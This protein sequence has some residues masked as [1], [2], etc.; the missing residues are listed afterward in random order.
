MRIVVDAMGTDTC[1][2]PDVEGAVLAAREL[3]DTIILV[4]DEIRVRAELDKYNTQGLDLRVVHAEDSITMTDTP[5][6]VG[7][8]KPRSS[9]HIGMALVRDGEADAF[10]TMGNTGVALVIA[11][12]FVLR[13]IRGVKRPA[14]SGIFPLRGK[15]IVFLDVGANADSKPE[16]LAQFAL[17]GSIYANNALGLQ[18]PRIGLLSNGEEEGKGTELVREATT[19]IRSLPLNFIG[20]IEPKEIFAAAADVVVGDGF[21]GNL[22]VKTYEASTRYLA[23][24]IRDEVKADPLSVLGGLMLRP[25][26]AR[27]RRRIDTFEVGGAPLLG[28][29]GVVIIGHG[30]SNGIAVKNAI[31]Q[32]HRAVEG[33]IVA[34]IDAA[35]NP[36]QSTA[37]WMTTDLHE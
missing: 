1:P 36:P 6:V 23:D 12:L 32:A 26:L 30:R 27:V 34:A 17:M 7:R 37:E 21:T 20:N 18:Q 29:Q 15:P 16:W 8:S 14:L 11:T 22:L 2:I 13:R 3:G 19:L 28:V 5:S 9:M 24:V 35:I 10:V 25:A 31:R 4:G 33:Q